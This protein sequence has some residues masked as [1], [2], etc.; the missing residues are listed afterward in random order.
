MLVY[1]SATGHGLRPT[2]NLMLRRL[3]GKQNGSVSLSGIE[4]RTLA[5]AHK[6]HQILRRLNTK[7]LCNK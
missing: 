2:L 1:I 5:N 3:K 7:T 4:L 6:C